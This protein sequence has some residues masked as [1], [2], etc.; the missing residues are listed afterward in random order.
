MTLGRNQGSISIPNI[1]VLA[2]VDGTSCLVNVIT[3]HAS[4]ATLDL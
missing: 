1:H 2:M 3:L 4:L